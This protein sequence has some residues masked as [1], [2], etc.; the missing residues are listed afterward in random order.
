[1]KTPEKRRGLLRGQG[2]PQDE[3]HQWKNMGIGPKG[4]SPGPFQEKSQGVCHPA[5]GARVAGK[6]SERALPGQEKIL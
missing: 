4:L 3:G 5:A 6:Q 1:M 2:K